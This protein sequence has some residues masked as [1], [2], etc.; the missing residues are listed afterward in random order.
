MRHMG[1]LAIIWRVGL[2]LLMVIQIV[3]TGFRLP[4]GV[5]V[6]LPR[7]VQM[8]MLSPHNA[9]GLAELLRP[10][11]DGTMEVVA[12][13]VK[14]M[15]GPEVNLVLVW[16]ADPVTV[17]SVNLEYWLY[18]RLLAQRRAGAPSPNAREC[19]IEWHSRI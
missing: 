18:P 2:I 15:V 13:Q 7:V 5:S 6:L 16:D 10:P 12:N 3:M 8:G 14:T 17:A 4:W 1:L 11:G 19:A 9:A